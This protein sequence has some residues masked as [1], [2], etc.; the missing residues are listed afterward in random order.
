MIDHEQERQAVIAEARKWYG[1]PYAHRQ[2]VL[3]AGVD[4][5]ML[6]VA[7]YRDAGVATAVDVPAYPADWALHRDEEKYIDVLLR[8][9]EEVPAPLPGD[10][11]LFQFG[12][13]FSHGGVV[14][15]WPSIIHSYLR[16]GCELVA[17]VTMDGRLAG[18][19]RR[20]FSP[21]RR[22]E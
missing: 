13:A 15:E 8:H 4:C 11:V 3:G 20:F 14:V 17:D 6:L 12:R 7:A 10:V 18:R 19:K 9:C 1:T 16:V 21:W 5:A 2:M 22:A